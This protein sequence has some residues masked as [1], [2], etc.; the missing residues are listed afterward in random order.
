MKIQKTSNLLRPVFVTII[1]L[2]ILISVTTAFAE[3]IKIGVI[4]DRVGNSAAWAKPVEEGIEMAFP[5]QTI[6]VDRDHS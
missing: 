4:T 2:G 6:H 3:T 5:T 1:G